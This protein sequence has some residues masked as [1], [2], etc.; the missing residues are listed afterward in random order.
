M[1]EV[2]RGVGPSMNKMEALIETQDIQ[3][4]VLGRVW[5]VFPLHDAI[6]WIEIQNNRCTL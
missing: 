4:F 2:I 5:V 1:A 6:F 3:V